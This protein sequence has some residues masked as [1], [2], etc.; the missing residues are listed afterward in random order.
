VAVKEKRDKRMKK[1]IVPLLGIAFVVAI[2]STGVFYGLFAGKLKSSSPETN[3]QS[4]V[5][6]ARDLERGTVI[7]AEDV[8]ESRIGGVL[9]GSFAHTNDTVGVTLLEAVQQNAPLLQDRVSSN[10]PKVNGGA[11]GLHTGMRAI[12]VRVFDSTGIIGLM[13][14]GSR[15]DV[16]AVSDRNGPTELRTIQQNVEVLAVNPQP[17]PS[18]GNR[19]PSP[20]VTL[21]ARAQDIDVIAVADSGARIRLAL[22]NPLD[23]GV[24]VRHPLALA[25]VFQSHAPAASVAAENTGRKNSQAHVVSAS[26]PAAAWDHPVNL[27]VQVLGVSPAALAELDSRLTS[28]GAGD[29][30]R[31]AAFRPESDLSDLVRKLRQKQ[32]LEIVSGWHLMAGVGRPISYRAGTSPNLIRV[33]FSPETDAAGKQNLNVRPQITL[34]RGDAT[35]TR[36]IAGSLPEGESFLVKGLVQDQND[37]KSLD[38]LFPGHSWTGRDLVILVTS[39][40][41]KPLAGTAFAQTNRGQ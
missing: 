31:V 7:K 9:K 2:V 29:V 22:R 10:D 28:A 18:G 35:L 14:P 20:V 12:S 6:A 23:E 3:G 4:I 15:V 27:Y 21:L 1:N 41:L 5:V 39:R 38:V 32:E 36:K 26:T 34:E 8:R 13:H 37:R 24:D 19:P 40:V 25:S 17:E 30:L 16:Q 11:S 33:Q